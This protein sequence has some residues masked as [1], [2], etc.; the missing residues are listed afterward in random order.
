MALLNNIVEFPSDAFKIVKHFRHPLPTRT[1]TIGPWLDC[2]SFLAWLSALTN[3]ALVY[4]FHPTAAAAVGL[5]APHSTN[6]AT[7]LADGASAGVQE[8][9]HIAVERTRDVVV[10]AL[11]IALAASHGYIILRAAVRHVLVRVLW[12]GSAEKAR[13]DDAA[14]EV[15]ERYFQSVQEAPPCA[16]GT[17]TSAGVR[18]QIPVPPSPIFAPAILPPPSPVPAPATLAPLAPVPDLVRAA[19]GEVPLPASPPP[20]PDDEF[21]QFDEGID[22]IRKGIKEA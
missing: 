3:A 7:G 13:M 4:L 12:I 10:R 1:D 14:A 5:R 15:K 9:E 19:E 17:G 2:L 11:F 8:H 6:T 18:L 22:E 21:W 16:G 20:P